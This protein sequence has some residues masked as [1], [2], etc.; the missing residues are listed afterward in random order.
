MMFFDL[1]VFTVVEFNLYACFS[2]D[3]FHSTYMRKSTEFVEILNNNWKHFDGSMVAAVSGNPNKFALRCINVVDDSLSFRFATFNLWCKFGI[4]EKLV[5]QC[6]G[7]IG[8]IIA[9][10]VIWTEN[11]FT[12]SAFFQFTFRLVGFLFEANIITLLALYLLIHSATNLPCI[13]VRTFTRLKSK[14]HF[15]LNV[16][17]GSAPYKN[18]KTI[19]LIF[20]NFVFCFE[21][22]NLSK[23][24]MCLCMGLK[25]HTKSYIMLLIFEISDEFHFNDCG[26]ISPYGWRETI[27]SSKYRMLAHY[28]Y[29][30]LIALQTEYFLEV[31]TDKFTN[32]LVLKTSFNIIIIRQH[33]KNDKI[34]CCLM[35]CFFNYS[36]TDCCSLVSTSAKFVLLTKPRIFETFSEDEFCSWFSSTNFAVFFL[37]VSKA[38]IT[39][40]SLSP[41]KTS[42]VI[43]GLSFVNFSQ[44]KSHSTS[45]ERN[46][47]SLADDFA[48]SNLNDIYGCTNSDQ[49]LKI[50]NDVMLY[51]H[52]CF[53]ISSFFYL[54]GTRESI[55]MEYMKK[56]LCEV[57]KI[58]FKAF[59]YLHTYLEVLKSIYQ[60]KLFIFF[61]TNG[62][63]QVI[64]MYEITELFGGLEIHLPN[65]IVYLFF[66][67]WNCAGHLYL[68]INKMC[69]V[70]SISDLPPE[71]LI[72]IFRYLDQRSLANATII[73]K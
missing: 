17:F 48:E 35:K 50:F 6:V 68:T 27:C 38:S 54:L 58:M 72:T 73:C 2:A 28:K 36:E 32:N 69:K 10:T 5:V 20:E 30:F 64:C 41:V 25:L 46:V 15:K 62:I 71:I 61:F 37:K 59:N 16:Q 33:G 65:E 39:R 42:S 44:S 12:E 60:T 24:E 70:R 23:L 13:T 19:S 55:P 67:K 4:V 29:K 63:A 1:S 7:A 47:L 26:N 57:H 9:E 34:C 52:H 56:V 22:K 53:Q 3:G 18:A 43:W 51:I 8:R 40:L 31:L 66:H 21:E 49:I 45:K 14:K 11:R